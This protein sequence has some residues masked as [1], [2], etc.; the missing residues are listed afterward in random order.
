MNTHEIIKM[1]NLISTV[2]GKYKTIFSRIIFIFLTCISNKNFNT[3]LSSNW[4][5]HNLFI[6][7]LNC[8]HD[9]HTGVELPLNVI[10]FVQ[11]YFLN[12]GSQSWGSLRWHLVHITRRL[13]MVSASFGRRK[14]PRLSWPRWRA[15]VVIC[16][17]NIP[18]KLKRKLY[19]TL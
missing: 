14:F 4:L 1:C 8:A 6:F 3:L 13:A 11:G 17:K 19:Q 2:N 5:H 15:L 9:L 7:Y 16:D 18:L 10:Y 12:R